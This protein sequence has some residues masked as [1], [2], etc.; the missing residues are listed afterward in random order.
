MMASAFRSNPVRG[1]QVERPKVVVFP[2]YLDCIDVGMIPHP[3]M[4][5]IIE[6][7]DFPALPSSA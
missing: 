2:K 4:C 1:Y 7:S 5:M 6:T 3:E